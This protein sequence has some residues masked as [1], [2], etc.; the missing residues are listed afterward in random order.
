MNISEAWIC[1]FP[2]A[3]SAS[4]A[5]FRTAIVIVPIAG[6]RHSG[7]QKAVGLVGQDL[8]QERHFASFSHFI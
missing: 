6:T 3:Q 8:R 7:E 1:G 5:K 2:V 4:I